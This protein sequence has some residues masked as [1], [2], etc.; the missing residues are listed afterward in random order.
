MSFCPNCGNKLNP[1]AQFCGGCGM[2]IA[3]VSTPSVDAPITPP[4]VASSV[5]VPTPGSPSVAVNEGTGSGWSQ[6]PQYAQAHQASAA[7]RKRLPVGAIVAIVL[8]VA[9]ILGVGAGVGYTLFVAHPAGQQQKMG[10][11]AD[12][13]KEAEEAYQ[14]VIDDYYAALSEY[15]KSGS[16]YNQS[17]FTTKHPYL[18]EDRLCD[19]EFLDQS[20]RKITYAYINLG[21]DEVPGLVV[22]AARVNGG[23]IAVSN[24]QETELVAAYTLVDGKPTIVGQTYH[25]SG[26]LSLVDNSYL[27]MSTVANDESGVMVRSEV[28]Y[29]FD[30]QDS[31]DYQNSSSDGVVY[32]NGAPIRTS[33]PHCVHAIGSV[34]QSVQ[35]GGQTT[36]VHPDG[37][38]TTEG[39]SSGATSDL[40]DELSK[41]YPDKS[42]ELEWKEPEPSSKDDSQASD[43][44]EPI[45]YSVETETITVTQP[46]DSVS[47]STQSTS[48]WT[49][50]QLVPSRHSDA[51][52]KINAAIKQSVLDTAAVTNSKAEQQANGSTDVELTSQVCISK[53]IYV[54]Y[55]SDSVVCFFDSSYITSYGAHG[56]SERGGIAFSLETGNQVLMSSVV[57]VD[58]GSLIDLTCTAEETYLA[59][60]P[61]RSKSAEV[62]AGTRKI[63]TDNQGKLKKTTPGLEGEECYCLGDEGMFYLTSDYEMGTFV[64]GTRNICIVGFGDQSVVGTG[65]MGYGFGRPT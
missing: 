61:V 28:Y 43:E 18:Y 24:S 49:Y 54:T 6:N 34:R 9:V 2:P 13:L 33:A 58:Q 46:H 23:T 26:S 45:T 64:E 47:G 36:V 59:A 38:T 51:V 21:N 10:Y 32:M 55:R 39:D 50:E 30:S 12:K 3:D 16:S 17:A 11:D 15:A 8:A 52:D 14:V 56:W 31:T 41:K 1:D 25:E 60:N 4:R 29:N 40:R 5:P 65:S 57:G 44:L 48:E 27:C 53:A 22:K 35:G 20:K 62:V 37:T 7:P 19:A 63:L 42:G